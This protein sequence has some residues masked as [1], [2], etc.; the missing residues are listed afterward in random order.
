MVPGRLSRP[1]MGATRR[2][3]SCPGRRDWWP[4]KGPASTREAP[5]RGRL[6]QDAAR[7]PRLPPGRERAGSPRPGGVRAGRGPGGS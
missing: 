3:Q 1:A 5:R 6:A 2:G 7:G 4:A